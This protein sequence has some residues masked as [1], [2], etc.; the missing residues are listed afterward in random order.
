MKV[1]VDN[2]HAGTNTVTAAISTKLLASTFHKLPSPL[3]HVMFLL[4]QIVA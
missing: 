2:V 1:L 4:P 3:Q